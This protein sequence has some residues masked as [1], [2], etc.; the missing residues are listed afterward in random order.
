MPCKVYAVV[1][2][3]YLRPLWKAGPVVAPLRQCVRLTTTLLVCLVCIICNYKSFHSFFLTLRNGCLHLEDTQV[4]FCA[5][6]INVFF[7]FTDVGLRHYFQSEV[8]RGCL[9]CVI[10]NSVTLHSFFFKLCL[11]IVHTL[12][13]CTFYFVHI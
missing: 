13:M 6:L 9:F 10:C 8:C 5:H 1:Q 12:K 7:I 3:F 4:L 11:I 2:P